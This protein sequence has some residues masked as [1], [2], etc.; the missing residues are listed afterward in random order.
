MLKLLIILNAF[1]IHVVSA[2]KVSAVS[3][4]LLFN[5]RNKNVGYRNVQCVNNKI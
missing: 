5:R 3:E 1:K 2:Y 4:L